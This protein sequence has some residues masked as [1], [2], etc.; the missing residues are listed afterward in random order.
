MIWINLDS[1]NSSHGH[2]FTRERVYRNG[3]WTPFCR[4]RKRYNSWFG[5]WKKPKPIAWCLAGRTITFAG[6]PSD[7]QM[8]E[9]IDAVR[10]LGLVPTDQA[11]AGGFFELYLKNAPER[12]DWK[13]SVPDGHVGTASIT[14]KDTPLKVVSAHLHLRG[15]EAAL[16]TLEVW[17][18][19]VEAIM[20]AL[21]VEIKVVSCE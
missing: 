17:G 13:I 2:F 18:R 12:P 14:Y 20:D 10:P 19:H 21:D 3:K 11:L 7:G 1:W 4:V 15:G 16:L 8:Q 5:Y 9:A 6:I